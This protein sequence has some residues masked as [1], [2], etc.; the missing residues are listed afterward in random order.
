MRRL[1]S[2]KYRYMLIDSHFDAD[3]LAKGR[4]F[5]AFFDELCQN[6]FEINITM[7]ED[8]G[9]FP[10]AY[11]ENNAYTSIAHALHTL[12]PYVSGDEIVK[13]FDYDIDYKDKKHKTAQDKDKLK[14]RFMDFWC[15]DKKREFEVW[16]EVKRTWLKLKCG[17]NTR[18]WF[19]RKAYL[20]MRETVDHIESLQFHTKS[21]PKITKKANYK[22]ALF[23]IPL[24]CKK[25]KIP[26]YYNTRFAPEIVEDYLNHFNI[27]RPNRGVLCAV[28]DLDPQGKK[29]CGLIYENDYTPYFALGAVIAERLSDVQMR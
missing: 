29:Q 27:N 18:L 23:T 11:N 20:R 17:Q 8:I 14:W 13:F 10:I 28:L 2:E 9:C 12:T 25:N 4:E 21:L 16:I 22:V 5:K 26:V 6:I 15:M 7:L 24:S 1:D 3:K 19:D